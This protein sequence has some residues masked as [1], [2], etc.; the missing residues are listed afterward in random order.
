L[1]SLNQL[2]E[3]SDDPSRFDIRTS[4]SDAIFQQDFQRLGFAEVWAVDFSDAY[5][6]VD[7]RRSADMF[8]FKPKQ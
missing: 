4:L 1:N 2:R 3:Y 6:A 7:P 5:S 8:C